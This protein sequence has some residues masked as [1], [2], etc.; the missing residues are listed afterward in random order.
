MA[1]APAKHAT[2]KGMTQAA[3]S[4]L[5]ALS[6]DEKSK[7]VYQYEDGER[8]FWYYPPMN[9]HGIALRDL[10]ADQRGIAYPLMA[11]GRP[12]R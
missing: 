9:S 2:A 10:Y 4:F 11:S 6:D 1:T 5:E 12:K 3:A 8:V 7:T